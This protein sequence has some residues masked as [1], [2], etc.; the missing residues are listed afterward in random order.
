[1]KWL[2]MLEFIFN[3]SKVELSQG[4][5]TDKRKLLF[6]L[7]R[8]ISR[9]LH[10]QKERK[11][12]Q[13]LPRLRIEK[14]QTLSNCTLTFV[15]SICSKLQNSQRGGTTPL[16]PMRST[17]RLLVFVKVEFLLAFRPKSKCSSWKNRVNKASRYGLCNH[18]KGSMVHDDEMCHPHK[19]CTSNVQVNWNGN[20]TKYCWRFS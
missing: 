18:L 7:N 15:C 13:E 14:G 9:R 3:P 1:M 12:L 20:P 6:W 5:L 11:I 19:E 17:L 2:W 16:I 10:Q 8:T 4:F